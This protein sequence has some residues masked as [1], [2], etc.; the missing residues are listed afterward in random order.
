M[1]DH[2]HSATCCVLSS[3][4]LALGEA[5]GVLHVVS[6]VDEF[7]FRVE[8][9]GVKSPKTGSSSKRPARSPA[10][11]SLH[12]SCSLRTLSASHGVSH[13]GGV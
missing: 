9:C 3:T 12:L 1:T 10:R 6:D 13:S 5:E 8:S 7:P 11:W 2:T 4:G